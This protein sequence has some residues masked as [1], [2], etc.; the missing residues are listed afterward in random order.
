M[1]APHSILFLDVDGVLN[2][3]R[4]RTAGLDAGRSAFDSGLPDAEHLALLARLVNTTGCQLVLSSTWRYNPEDEE[5]IEAALKSAGIRPLYGA[6]PYSSATGSSAVSRGKEIMD[7]LRDSKPPSVVAWIAVDDLDLHAW[8]SDM[9]D[10]DHFELCDDDVGL[11]TANVDS[12]IAK[13]A[14][15]RQPRNTRAGRMS[16]L[17]SLESAALAATLQSAVRWA[18]AGAGISIDAWPARVSKCLLA[19]LEEGAAPPTPRS[20]VAAGASSSAAAKAETKAAIAALGQLMTDALNQASRERAAEPLRTIAAYLLGRSM[21][22]DASSTGVMR[23]TVCKRRPADQP[24]LPKGAA[25]YSAVEAEALEDV[26]LAPGPITHGPIVQ[27]L[28][29]TATIWARGNATGAMRCRCWKLRE[30]A[31]AT[32]TQSMRQR[33]SYS[34]NDGWCVAPAHTAMAVLEPACDYAGRATL[35]GLEHGAYYEFLVETDDASGARFGSFRTPPPSEQARP[36]GNGDASD[37][38]CSFVFGSGIGGHGHGRLSTS[39]GPIERGEKAQPEGGFPVF[40]TLLSTKPDFFVCNGDAIYA[41]NTIDATSS[42]LWTKGKQFVEGEGMAHATDLEGFRAR[43]RYHLA[44]KALM[45]FYSRVPVFA[46]WNDHEVDED[47][48]AER[49]RLDGKAELLEAGSRAWFEYN[50]HQGPPEEPRRVYRAVRWG[51][52]AEML[53]LDCR[54]YRSPNDP[55]PPPVIT[56]PPCIKIRLTARDESEGGVKALFEVK[57]NEGESTR[58]SKATE[59]NRES[60][61]TESNRSSSQPDAAPAAE[62]PPMRTMLGRA[63]LQWLLT[64]L[65]SSD[66][67]WKFVCTS[68]PLTFPTGKTGYDGWSDGPNADAYGTEAELKLILQY[69]SDAKIRNVVFLSGDVRYPFAMSYDPFGHGEPLVHEIGAAPLHGLSLP[70]PTTDSR[71]HNSTL[72]YGIDGIT[73]NFNPTMQTFGRCAIDAKGVATFTLHEVA[74]DGKELFELRLEPTKAA[75]VTSDDL[76]MVRE[77]GEW[78]G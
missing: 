43:Y 77:A 5:A 52:H 15:Q 66:A 8:C 74:S 38:A 61:A 49:L 78:V 40:R 23:I 2:S 48:G 71:S 46:T 6:T 30:A 55:P 17:P 64:T 20:T 34:K 36:T 1:S 18:T 50:V 76:A 75:A 44:D 68:V 33:R 13:L 42:E 9:I 51:P 37:G 32:N 26:P 35:R 28:G 57:K 62:P 7:W 12:A 47:W 58:S 4:T 65:G 70:M 41:N 31:D 63:Q 16:W 67:T 22:T 72:L 11:T 59:S 10:E 53:I 29:T 14:R 27:V 45:E 39:L 19:T 24:A 60:K 54:S 21:T 56:D 73:T 69:I 25:V 3:L